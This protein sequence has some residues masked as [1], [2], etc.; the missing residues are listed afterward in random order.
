MAHDCIWQRC[1]VHSVGNKRTCFSCTFNSVS[2]GQE[3]DTLQTQ[4]FCPIRVAMNRSHSWK[5][6][7]HVEANFNLNAVWQF[8]SPNW[9]IAAKTNSEEDPKHNGEMWPILSRSASQSCWIT[10]KTIIYSED[11]ARITAK[12]KNRNNK[13]D[14]FLATPEETFSTFFV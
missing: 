4:Y 12:E 6:K 1:V 10:T 5:S 7:Y 14:I 11:E 9:Q 3:R 8:K 13:K 2:E